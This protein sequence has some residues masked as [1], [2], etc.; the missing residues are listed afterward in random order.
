MENLDE[1]K[2]I[3]EILKDYTDS[4]EIVKR[5]TEILSLVSFFKSPERI[6]KSE[7]SSFHIRGIKDKRLGNLNIK[8]IHQMEK[9]ILKNTF[10]Y[11]KKVDFQFPSPAKYPK[12]ETFD[13]ILSLWDERMLEYTKNTIEKELKKLH[14]QGRIEITRGIYIER[15]INTNSLDISYKRTGINIYLM[16]WPSTVKKLL[17]ME[18]KI[19]KW[20][21]NIWQMWLR[22]AHEILS[23]SNISSVDIQEK[24]IPVIFAPEALGWIYWPL[25]HW[26]SGTLKDS[27]LREKLGKKSF[28]SQLTVIDNPTANFLINSSPFDSEGVPSRDIKLIE[29]GIP[30]R[31]LYDLES[32][33]G[34]GEETTGS[35]RFSDWISDRGHKKSANVVPANL[36]VLPGRLSLQEILEELG[37]SLMIYDCEYA[38]DV[39][40]KPKIKV[41]FGYLMRGTKVEGVVTDIMLEVELFEA[42]STIAFVSKETDISEGGWPYI[43]FKNIKVKQEKVRKN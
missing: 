38:W 27:P 12:V 10:K 23:F 22:R 39:A 31:L 28:S 24:S 43:A 19:G 11:G 17:S 18:F 1:I 14:I 41:T 6:E 7:S 33:D 15:I 13:P 34:K 3:S 8:S 4:F 9:E 21:E 5:K 20:D 40:E 26:I 29:A 2:K 16:L 42:L 30:K 37:R 35:R 25:Y 32:A 36:R